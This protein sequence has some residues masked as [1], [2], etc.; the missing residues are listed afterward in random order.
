MSPNIQNVCLIL[1]MIFLIIYSINTLLCVI[2]VAYGRLLYKSSI[3]VTRRYESYKSDHQLREKIAIAAVAAAIV[4]SNNSHHK[5]F[6]PPP[7]AIV[8]AWQAVMRSDILKRQGRP[9]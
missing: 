1:F 6:T 7:T 9:R 8:S 2:L 5:V 4:M 3:A